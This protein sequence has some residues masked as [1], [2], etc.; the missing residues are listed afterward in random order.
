[1][2]RSPFYVVMIVTADI[3]NAANNYLERMGYG[4]GNFSVPIIATNDPDNAVPKAYG[5][6]VQGS[7]A[8]RTIVHRKAEE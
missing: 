5:C 7:R 4:P 3:V 6:M 8:F 1:M 2:T